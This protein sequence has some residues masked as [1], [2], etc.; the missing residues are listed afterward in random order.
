MGKPELDLIDQCAEVQT[1]GLSTLPGNAGGT[2]PLFSAERVV[3][4]H[5]QPSLDDGKV[6]CHDVFLFHNG[7]VKAIA[8][9]RETTGVRIGGRE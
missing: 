3:L 8:R 2:A 1:K 7:F 5:S 4:Q 6:G 9:C